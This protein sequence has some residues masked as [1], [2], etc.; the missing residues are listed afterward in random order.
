MAEFPLQ[1]VP[2]ELRPALDA[3]D[4]SACSIH[5]AI[6]QSPRSAFSF[7]QLQR[8]YAK[9]LQLTRLALQGEASLTS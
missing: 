9:R 1:Q 4:H 7:S 5:A 3:L 8:T 6:V 2:V